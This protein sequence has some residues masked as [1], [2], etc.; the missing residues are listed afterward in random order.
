[1]KPEEQ[2]ATRSAP[3]LHSTTNE[4][5]YARPSQDSGKTSEKAAKHAELMEQVRSREERSDELRTSYV[6]FVVLLR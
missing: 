1:M 4:K 2:A 6:G 5:Q 3:P